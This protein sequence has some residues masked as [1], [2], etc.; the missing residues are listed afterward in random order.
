[1]E[2]QPNEILNRARQENQLEREEGRLWRWSLWLLV[3]L[4]LAVALLTWERLESLPYSLGALPAGLLVLMVLF[5]AYAYGRRGKY[6]SSKV[7][8]VD[9]RAESARFRPKTNS[10]SSAR[11]SNA[12]NEISSN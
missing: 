5:A 11:C 6:R 9:S 2:K 3:L 7:F 4:A 1:V 10:T 8:C 12:R